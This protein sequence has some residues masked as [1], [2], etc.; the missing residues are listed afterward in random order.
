MILQLRKTLYKKITSDNDTLLEAPNHMLSNNFCITQVRIGTFWEIWHIQ[1][2][3]YNKTSIDPKYGV[4]YLKNKVSV[5]HQSLLV[6]LSL[7][8]TPPL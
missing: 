2:Q 4:F 8:V 7:R 1:I 5:P 3:I 6:Q